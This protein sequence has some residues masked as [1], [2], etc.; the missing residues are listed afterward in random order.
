MSSIRLSEKHGVNPTIGVCFFCGEHTNEIAMLGRLKGDAEAPRE[1]VLS[2]KPCD[3]CEKLFEQGTVILEVVPS[4][5][6]ENPEISK[7]YSP[8]GRY[9]VISKG[10]FPH[11]RGLM[12]VEDF[13]ELLSRSKDEAEVE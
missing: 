1:M 7:G 12:P 9:C 11:Q 8:T 13:T 10:I 4:S 3:A 5:E 6:S 2:Y